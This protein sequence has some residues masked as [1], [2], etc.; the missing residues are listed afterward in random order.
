MD[1]FDIARRRCGPQRR[2][3][4]T[5]PRPPYHTCDKRTFERVVATKRISK[6]DRPRYNIN[7][8]ERTCQITKVASVREEAPTPPALP[9]RLRGLARRHARHLQHELSLPGFQ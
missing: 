4:R 8:V 3:T 6:G 1:N 7:R 9:R 2:H 5:R